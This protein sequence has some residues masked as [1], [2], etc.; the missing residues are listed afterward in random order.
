MLGEKIGE[1]KGRTTSQ[2]VTD[3]E[4]GV[5]EVETTFETTGT[6]LGV[7]NRELGTYWSVTAPGGGMQGHGHG[8]QFTADG[9]RVI[10]RGMGV[11]RLSDQGGMSFRG[12]LT[13]ETESSRLARLNGMCGV[14]E[15]DE[16]PD[17]SARFE[18]WEWR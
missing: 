16:G 15:Y 11:G 3:V 8:V 14:F 5:A 4:G 17:G 12:C 13:F 7:E 6:L 9:E 2:R 10:W 18:V 1:G